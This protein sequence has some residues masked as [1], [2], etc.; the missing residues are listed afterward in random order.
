M[1]LI[2]LGA[3]N[4]QITPTDLQKLW[5]GYSAFRAA[6]VCPSTVKR[7]YQKILRRIDL[8][9]QDSSTLNSAPAIR[10]WLTDRY[11]PETARRTL[12]QLQAAGRWGVFS[13]LLESNP[14]EG[15]AQYLTSKRPSET[16]WAAFTA[17]ERDQVI[18]A[19]EQHQPYFAAWV[20]FLFWTGCR[21]EEAAALRWQH[22]S[23]DYAEILV[24]DAAPVDTGLIH[25]TKN[26]QVTRFPCN[27]RLAG[28]LRQLRPFPCDRLQ[29]VFTGP[30]GGRLDYR[31]FQQRVWKPL[32]E[33]LADEGLIGFYLS[34]YHCR[35][36]FITLALS[37]LSVKDVAYLCRVSEPVIL[38]HYASRSRRI[39]IP[40]F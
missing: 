29:W 39:S 2:R 9:V 3:L 28:L 8:M 12:V 32:V 36:T 7:D 1:N 21:P 19:F 23:A 33:G 27:D 11:S 10:D 17:A 16:A 34:Q 6:Q 4:R 38:K 20:K 25:R 18:A 14:F 22:I 13:G 15:L 31:N 40:E 24:Q 37:H 5:S 35:H 30:R 26:Y